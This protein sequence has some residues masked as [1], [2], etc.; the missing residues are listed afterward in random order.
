[1][2]FRVEDSFL[3]D[4]R[5]KN[6]WDMFVKQDVK[7]VSGCDVTMSYE[8]LEAVWRTYD[9]DGKLYIF[10]IED[11]N[12]IVAIAP[13]YAR[14]KRFVFL[15]YIELATVARL[16]CGR[17]RFLVKNHE[18]KYFK[19]L[20]AFINDFFS[21][22]VRFNFC[23]VIG[24]ETERMVK[25]ASST[26]KLRK[27]DRLESPYIEIPDK[28][29]EMFSSL[30]KKLRYGIRN[31][32]KKLAKQGAVRVKVFTN[33]DFDELLMSIFAIE[34]RSWKEDAGTSITKNNRQE[35]FYRY[36]T[37]IAG[38]EGLLRCFVLYIEDNPI[39]YVYGLIFEGVFYDFKESYC[40]SYTKISPGQVL[41]S[42][43]FND[44]CESKIHFFDFMGNC[45]SYKMQWTTKTYSQAVYMIYMN[46]ILD[47]IFNLK[48]QGKNFSPANIIKKLTDA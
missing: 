35:Q 37:P 34:K 12:K 17:E 13:V 18:V 6:A 43:L 4:Q 28:W 44:L 38:R 2:K 20:L 19:A 7:G 9:G 5:T 27:I 22:P 40:K 33:D 16:Y 10:I 45:E 30:R 8:W 15:R 31:S 24:S 21:H 25:A 11:N 23:A 3:V 46:T 32:E 36:F 47:C 39:A 42:Y 48:Q 41:K 14:E 26:Y 1:M 29:E